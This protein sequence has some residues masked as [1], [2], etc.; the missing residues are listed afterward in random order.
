MPI[1]RER[2]RRREA[3]STCAAAHGSSSRANGL[4]TL[5][6]QARVSLSHDPGLD[7]RGRPR[8][9]DLRGGQCSRQASCCSPSRHACSATFW[10]SRS[11]SSFFITVYAGSGLIADDI[12]ANALQLYLSRPVT[13]TQYIAGKSRDSVGRARAGHLAPGDAAAV[14]RARVHGQHDVRARQPLPRSGDFRCSRSSRSRVGVHRFS[15]CRRSARAAGSWRSCTRVLCSSRR[16][17]SAPRGAPPTARSFSWISVFA[18][19]SRR[20]ATS[21][22][23]CPRVTTRRRRLGR[24][25]SRRSLRSR[26]CVLS[27]RIRAI[28]VVT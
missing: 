13:R 2:Y 24:S 5:V 19:V 14:A 3:A 11:C 28:E 6:A 15:R 10:I 18:N 27:R 22:S 12:R 26:R 1:H 23:A 17:S 7:S 16:R 20:S 8:R 9:A 25:S 21:F 4:R